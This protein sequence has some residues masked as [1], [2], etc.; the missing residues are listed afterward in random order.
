MR[1]VVADDTMLTRQGLVRLLGEAGVEV[2]AEAEDAVNLPRLVRSTRPDVVLVDIPKPPTFTNEGLVAAQAIRAEHPRSGARLV[3][4]RRTNIAMRLLHGR[5]SGP[6][7]EAGLRHRDHGR[8]TEAPACRRRRD[9]DRPAIV[10]RLISR[11]RRENNV[12]VGFTEQEHE[13][14]ELSRRGSDQ[15]CDRRPTRRDWF[16]PSR[17]TSRR[18]SPKATSLPSRTTS[19]RRTA[20]NPDVLPAPDVP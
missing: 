15:P 10:S 16:G 3:S 20:D 2:V 11:K 4:V 14:L 13:V 12:A 17:R 1:V 7:E 6:A 9:R 5:R 19:V 18:L 8:Y